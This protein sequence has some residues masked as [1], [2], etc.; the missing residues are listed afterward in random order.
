MA[1]MIDGLQ[2]VRYAAPK[3]YS[4][5]VRYSAST[6]K[7]SYYENENQRR[8]AE[9]QR[10][11]AMADAY[12]RQQQQQQPPA[13]YK[14]Q[15]PLQN[16]FQQTQIQPQVNLPGYAFQNTKQNTLKP[17]P[18]RWATS[19]QAKQMINTYQSM[20]QPDRW[21]TTPQ[22]KQYINNYLDYKKKQDEELRLLRS[23]SWQNGPA[24]T[25]FYQGY[26]P[27]IPPSKPTSPTAPSGGYGDY[28]ASNPPYY[29]GGGGGGSYTPK[30]PEWWVEMV[31]WRI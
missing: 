21:A 25:F 9:A 6:T 20:A 5:P 11:Q 28:Y 27:P 22:A 4:Q 26:G 13:Y 18:D 2:K 29:S 30:P 19:P 15:T 23:M 1:I 10:M 12:R 8:Q 31:Q 17:Q 3:A 14:L 24:G 7:K 16:Q